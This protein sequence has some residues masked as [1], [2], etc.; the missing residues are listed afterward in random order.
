M[1]RAKYI[2]YPNLV[3]AIENRYMFYNRTLDYIEQGVKEGNVF[4][5]APLGDLDIGRTEMD[6]DKLKKGYEEGYFVAEG[7]HDRMME[8]LEG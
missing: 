4:V 8:F 5:I 1:I 7:L 3:H 6:K 2:R